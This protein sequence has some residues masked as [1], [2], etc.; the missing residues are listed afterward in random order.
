MTN[1]LPLLILEF[2]FCAVIGFLVP[3]AFGNKVESAPVVNSESP[4]SGE[5]AEN[6]AG[7][8]EVLAVTE[9]TD[10][11][12]DP[13]SKKYS[14]TVTATSN[15]SMFYLA[16]KD[17][18]PIPGSARRTGTFEV[19]ATPDGIYYV[20]VTDAAGHESEYVLVS[21]C[22]TEGSAIPENKRVKK[23]ELQRLLMDKNPNAATKALQGRIA[24]SVRY[25]FTNIDPEQDEKGMEPKHYLGIITNLQIGHWKSVSVASVGYNNAGQMNQARISIEY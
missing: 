22:K 4:Q 8:G 9:F 10:P 7:V 2:L 17:R 25:Q 3:K 14:F 5:A 19:P 11:V 15:A 12:Y 1:K 24:S 6:P 21:G 13:Q 18:K 20:Y 16:D 23:E